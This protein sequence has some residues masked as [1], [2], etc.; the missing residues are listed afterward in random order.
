MRQIKKEMAAAAAAGKQ[1]DHP[2]TAAGSASP[3]AGVELP[4]GAAASQ[5]D[6]VPA[7]QNSGWNDA[8]PDPSG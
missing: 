1:F 3:A 2:G 7:R 8:A 5:T 4:S 6:R